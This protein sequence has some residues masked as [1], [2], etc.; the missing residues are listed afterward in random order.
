MK[1]IW[2]ILMVLAVAAACATTKQDAVSADKPAGVI[3]DVVAAKATVDA[4]DY[5]NRTAVLKDVQGNSHFFKA[6]PEIRNFPQMKVG[7]EVICEYYQSVVVLVDKADA[8]PAAEQ[9]QV[10]LRAPQGAKPGV[11]IADIIDLTATVEK[12]D[13]DKRMVTLK[14]PEGKIINRKVDERVKNFSNIKKGDEVY[15]RITEAM[16]IRVETPKK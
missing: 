12:I 6:G 16:A 2:S 14:G 9:G 10:V 7:D 1:K 5:A 8:Q 4:I 3:A 13:Y 15:I 11:V